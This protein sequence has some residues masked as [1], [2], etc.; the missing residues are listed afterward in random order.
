MPLTVREAKHHLNNQLKHKWQLEWNESKQSEMKTIQPTVSLHM[1]EWNF[2]RWQEIKIHRLRLGT[3]HNLNSYY[4]KIGKHPDGFCETCHCYDSV[5]HFLISCKKYN[6][7]RSNLQN[8]LNYTTEQMT[9]N[10][11]FKHKNNIIHILKFI[12]NAI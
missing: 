11:L 12:R 10:N 3:F 8:A 2:P 7:C 1:N 5:K 9:L 4:L 6:Y